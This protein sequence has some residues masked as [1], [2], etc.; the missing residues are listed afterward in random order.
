MKKIDNFVKNT[1]KDVPKK[2]RERIIE[3][4]KESLT[5]KVEDLMEQGLSEQEAIDKAVM[6]FG[7]KEDY[8]EKEHKKELK[9]KRFKTIRHYRND[10][11]FSVFGALILIG[12]LI[13][14]NLY[15]TPSIIWFVLPMLAILWWPLAVLY[16]YLN[17]K[18]NRRN[19]EDE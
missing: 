4:V 10:F 19:N 5:E 2:D 13:F 11:F 12:M 16:H 6:E 14:T 8:F 3:Q 7:S 18:E 1:F 15:Y 9:D 17:K